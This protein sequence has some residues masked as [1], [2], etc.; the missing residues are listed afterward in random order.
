MRSTHPPVSPHDII[1]FA[2]QRFTVPARMTA[3]RRQWCNYDVVPLSRIHE[4][5]IKINFYCHGNLPS[6]THCA[7]EFFRLNV[8]LRINISTLILIFYFILGYSP[9]SFRSLTPRPRYRSTI[10]NCFFFELID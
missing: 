4:T 7:I 2:V 3:R 10:N 9:S 8:Y 5:I 1:C 6:S